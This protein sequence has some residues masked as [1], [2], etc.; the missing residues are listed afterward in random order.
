MCES[1]AI[2]FGLVRFLYIKTGCT[3]IDA[4]DDAV[5][6]RRRA[7]RSLNSYLSVQDLSDMTAQT[8][9]NS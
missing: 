7:R 1:P 3:G 4:T 8:K 2:R 6:M 9:K 5:L